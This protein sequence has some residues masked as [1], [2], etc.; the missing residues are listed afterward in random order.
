MSFSKNVDYQ[1]LPTKIKERLTNT[2]Y[3]YNSSKVFWDGKKLKCEHKLRKCYCRQCGGS[4]YCE[5]KRIKSVCVICTGGS[6]CQHKKLRHRCQQC[7]GGSICPHKR[8]K[9]IC[10]QCVGTSI[11]KHERRKS[12]C[13]ECNGSSVCEHKRL[14]TSCK[15]CVGGSR[16]EHNIMRASCKPCNGSAICVHQKHRKHC[17]DCKGTEICQH[18]EIKQNCSICGP[19]SYPNRWCKQCCYKT[20]SKTLRS[21]PFCASCYYTMN[22]DVECYR[23]YQTKER[24]VYQLLKATFPDF[25]IVYNKTV[26][27]GCSLKRPDFLIDF[28]TY[29]V[30]I[31]VDENQ[32]ASYTC[33]NK[34]TMTLFKDV[35]NRPLVMLRFN[36][37]VYTDEKGIRHNSCFECDDK[38]H[39][40]VE[41]NEWE[42]RTKD[43]IEAIQHH[44]TNEPKKEL[45]QQLLFFT[46]NKKVKSKTNE[47]DD[48]IDVDEDEIELEK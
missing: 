24:E 25:T 26:S 2:F 1:Q 44:S 19:S 29:V 16:C 31:E 41:K 9:D 8:R 34:R 18:I 10:V 43:L 14:R 39:L 40:V 23:Q 42:R 3:V 37:D 22:P 38:F 15:D 13:I 30:I 5:H 47:V 21:Y 27:N 46:E 20:V 33:E 48:E 45:T 28:G 36:P 32:H 11:C 4:S 7:S 12:N 6:V 17:I 35:G